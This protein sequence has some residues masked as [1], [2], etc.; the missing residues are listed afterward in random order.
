MLRFAPN[1]P[2]LARELGKSFCFL[3]CCNPDALISVQFPPAVCMEK[4]RH[5]FLAGVAGQAQAETMAHTGPL[6]PPGEKPQNQL[7]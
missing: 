5:P 2:Q 1:G 7:K 3:N 4:K 6:E